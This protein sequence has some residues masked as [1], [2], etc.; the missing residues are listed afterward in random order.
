[1]R[2]NPEELGSVEITIEKSSTGKITAHFQTESESTRQ[3]LQQG[4]EHLRTTLES[5]GSKVGDLKISCGSSSSNGNESSGNKPQQF[6]SSESRSQ[7]ASVS[8]GILN[9]EVDPTDHLVSLR[10]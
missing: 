2:L 3:I 8:E 7:R 6:G 10:A 5:T 9:H 1:M 4:L